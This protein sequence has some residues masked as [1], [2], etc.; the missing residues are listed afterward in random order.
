M[1]IRT[2]AI[3][4]VVA[5]SMLTFAGCGSDDSG[6]DTKTS[7]TTTSEAT[8][9]TASTETTA[10]SDTTSTTGEPS[11]TAAKAPVQIGDQ[12]GLPAAVADT[13]R[14]ILAAATEC[15]Y[16]ALQKIADENKGAFAFEQGGDSGQTAANYWRS[17]DASK[18]VTARLTQLLSTPGAVSPEAGKAYVWPAVQAG[19]T[20]AADYQ[21]IVDSGA[22]S[23]AEVAAFRKD[24]LYTGYRIA[25]LPSGKWSYFTSGG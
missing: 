13:R 8:A 11:C 2:N 1:T 14:R 12:D 25:I 4:A 16:D 20:T 6:S 15:D 10:T 23:A 3:L 19:K 22:Y 21:A 17:G 5:L 24:D 18:L 7:S 9:T